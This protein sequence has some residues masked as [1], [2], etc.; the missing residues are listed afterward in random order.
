MIRFTHGPGRAKNEFLIQ[1]LLWSSLKCDLPLPWLASWRFWSWPRRKPLCTWH[2]HPSLQSSRGAPPRSERAQK[3]KRFNQKSRISD[4]H[5]VRAGES[6]QPSPD[7]RYAYR[8]YIN[9]GQE[10]KKPRRQ[11]ELSTENTSHL[12]RVLKNKSQSEQTRRP[13]L[14]CFDD[15]KEE[16]IRNTQHHLVSSLDVYPA[17]FLFFPLLPLR[18]SPTPH[19]EQIRKG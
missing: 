6:Q 1:S 3:K 16:A 13:L 4:V 9:Q 7:S 12:G 19:G 17:P 11:S 8:P 10:G 15:Y 14:R 2:S 18:P 5:L